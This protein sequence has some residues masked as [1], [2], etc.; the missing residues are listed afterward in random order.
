[1]VL[2]I[3]GI[4]LNGR[5]CAGLDENMVKIGHL[6]AQPL[7]H[8]FRTVYFFAAAPPLPNPSPARGEGLFLSLLVGWSVIPFV[9]DQ[10]VKSSNLYHQE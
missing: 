3:D 6:L 10:M 1:M 8:Q 5:I 4:D 2:Y 9:I 7:V